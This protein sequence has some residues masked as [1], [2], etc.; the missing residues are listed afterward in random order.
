M[1][2]HSRIAELMLQLWERQAR[3]GQ[4]SR[5]Q[6]TETLV[7]VGAFQS[8]IRATALCNARIRMSSPTNE[9]ANE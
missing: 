2:T 3:P 5:A 1:L 8:A 6:L 7:G 9:L 4:D